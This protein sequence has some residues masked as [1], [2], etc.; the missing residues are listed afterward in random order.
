MDFPK[1]QKKEIQ[2]FLF[3]RRAFLLLIIIFLATLIGNLPEK[4]RLANAYQNWQNQKARQT[5]GAQFSASLNGM[6]MVAGES[7]TK[8][9]SPL[10]LAATNSTV[11]NN[12]QATINSNT[13][14]IQLVGTLADVNGKMVNGT[15]S[16]RFAIYDTDR[17]T[18]D[19]YPSDTDKNQ[20]IWEETQNVDIK[21]GVFNVDLGKVNNLPTTLAKTNTQFYLAMRVEND[22][23]MVPRKKIAPSFFALNSENAITLNGKKIGNQSGD[24]PILNQSGQIDIQNLPIGTNS[25]QLVVGNDKRFTL[26]AS[27]Q[28]YFTISG[29]QF[30]LNKI[31]LGS[32]IQGTLGV[33]Q[34]G[35]GLT[36][37][38]PGDLL[39]AS[40][41]DTLSKLAIGA[42]GQVLAV[43]DNGTLNW[44]TLIGNGTETD[45]RLPL[46]GTSGNLLQSDGSVWTSWTPNYLTSYTET[47]PTIYAWAKNSTKPTYTATEVGLGN[48]TNESK[49][50][51]FSNP[52][53]TGTVSGITAAMV[54]LGNVPNLTFSGSN[55][56][57]ET[58]TSIKTK[59]GFATSTSD[60]YLT[61]AD[62]NIFNGKQNNL[63]FTPYDSTN[64]A[65]YISTYN[66]TDPIFL[67]SQAH[68]ITAAHLIILS[69]TSGINTGDNAPNTLYSGL[70]TSKQ[71]ALNGTGFVKIS[72]TTITYD[73]SSYVTGTPWTGMGYL[74]SYTETDPRLPLAGTSGNLL[75]S[76][77]SVWTSWTPNYLTSYTETDPTIY[78]WAKNST[79]P[80]YTAT[81]VG[82]GN[83]TN[84]SKVTMFSNPTFTG[85]VSGITAAMVG[86]GNVPNLTFSGSNTGDETQTSIKTK[87]GFATSTSD[88]Y[89]TQADW[90]IFN[91]K[92]PAG[93]YLTGTKV[94][95]FNTRTGA[96]TL[97][98]TDVTNALTFTPYN[99]TNPNNYI[100][101]NQTITLSGDIAGSGTTSIVT[102]LPN[103][104]SSLGTFN[105]L[106][107]NAKGQVT[108]GSNAGYLTAEADTL[109]TV[110]ARGANTIVSVA[111]NAAQGTPPFSVT[112]TTKVAN[113]NADLLDG[114]D[115]SAFGDATAANQT[116]IL[117]R[118]GTNADGA[119]M[120]STLFAGQKYIANGVDAVAT[121]VNTVVNGVNT[122]VNSTSGTSSGTFFSVGGAPNYCKEKVIDANGFILNYNIN[123]YLLCAPGLY[124]NAG[125]CNGTSACGT[126]TTVTDIDGNVYNTVSISGQC[127]MATNIMTTKYPDGTAIT[128]G[129]TTNTWGNVDSAYYAYPPNTANT[130]EETLANIVANNLGFVYQWSA[131]MHG[132]TAEGAQ[133]IC[134]AGWHVPTDAEQYILESRLKDLNATCDVARNGTWDCASAGTKLK[135]GGSSGANVPL[136]G[137]RSTDGS[138]YSRGTY[139][140]LW[141][142]SPSSASAWYRNLYSAGA[143]VGRYANSKANGFSVRCLKN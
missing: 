50:T 32:D 54:G 116:Q 27:G 99:S 91:N 74:T 141:S 101:G 38:S 28:K 51:M 97:N 49:V 81:E 113:L 10:V 110:T 118:I 25:N 128:R 59:L 115:S 13:K 77:G 19:P 120:S 45:P 130:A 133:G 21:S 1:N 103:V 131:A 36:N 85:T 87:L 24:I 123:D 47:D 43:N 111:F 96:V 23:E 142:S 44:K 15:Y 22:S 78:A 26:S 121:N 70:A 41:T 63:G 100:T 58:Q 66:E 42:A 129:G 125:V 117:T 90:N 52:T 140:N 122:L 8:N 119:S 139:A 124:C 67:A 20:R 12:I 30:K 127:W 76:D 89:L 106:T 61:Q 68:N 29:Q 108:G 2:L 112:S 60:G 6:A 84:E 33:A 7:Q 105:N 88:G 17:T 65:G 9:N 35:T 11:S 109:S 18:V 48:V 143:T 37:F 14:T 16:I 53:F 134:P 92:Q 107:V 82:L 83:V 94:D 98:G 132:S 56:G 95:S 86:L 135:I 34:G 75:Q 55:T 64:P 79:K 80:T 62:W 102:T 72:G 39:Y 31:D 40:G 5:S 93:S 137:N 114:F 46:A 126:T 71:D 73:N 136:A 138:F 69:N 3:F 104:N 57:D 4:Y